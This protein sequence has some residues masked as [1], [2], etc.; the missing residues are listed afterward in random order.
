MSMT[1]LNPYLKRLNPVLGNYFG[2]LATEIEIRLSPPQTTGRQQDKQ[3]WRLYPVTVSP[4]VVATD[5]FGAF[6]ERVSNW[7]DL[8]LFVVSRR[9]GERKQQRQPSC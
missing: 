4:L 5:L 8:G 6:T 7:I 3:T 1:S 9:P 2:L